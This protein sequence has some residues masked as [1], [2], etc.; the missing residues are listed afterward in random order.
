[1]RTSA[2]TVTSSSDLVTAWV[3]YLASSKG[4]GWKVAHPDMKIN[5]RPKSRKKK[6]PLFDSV[7]IKSCKEFRLAPIGVHPLK[8]DRV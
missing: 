8:P 7:L 3:R 2:V 4:L 5:K 1:V 6:R